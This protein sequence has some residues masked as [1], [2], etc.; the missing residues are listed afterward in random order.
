MLQPE[1]KNEVNQARQGVTGHHVRMVLTL[2]V[3]GVAVAF[4]IAYIFFFAGAPNPAG[5]T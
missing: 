5:V 3:I 1:A 2:G 4:L